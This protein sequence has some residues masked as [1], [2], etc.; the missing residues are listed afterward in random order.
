MAAGAGGRESARRVFDMLQIGQGSSDVDEAAA[1]VPREFPLHLDG[2]E[3][4]RF[5]YAL[6]LLN[7]VGLG[8]LS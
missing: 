5:R 3:R 7:K 8:H 4:M 1:V 2:S 6:F